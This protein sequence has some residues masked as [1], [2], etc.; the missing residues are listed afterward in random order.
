MVWLE[1][2]WPI[3]ESGQDLANGFEE[4]LRREVAPGH[5]LHGILVEAVG[6]H[7]GCDDV[8][9]RLLDGTGRV[10]VV[11]LT[12][13]QSPPEQPPWPVTEVFDSLEAW[14][15]LRMKRDHEEY[16]G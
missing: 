6:R 14:A 2:W 8:L 4:E 9:F 15:E 5:P 10:A 16:R 12:W 3:A 11:H 13:T 1:P 7:N